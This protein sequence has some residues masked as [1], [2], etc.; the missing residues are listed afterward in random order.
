MRRR[1]FKLRAAICEL[2]SRELL[3]A[4]ATLSQPSR[5]SLFAL[6]EFSRSSVSALAARSALAQLS[7]LC[8]LS[9]AILKFSLMIIIAVNSELSIV[10]PQLSRCIYCVHFSG[11]HDWLQKHLKATLNISPHVPS[12]DH[13][14]YMDNPN[15]LYLSFGSNY[16]F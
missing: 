2:R 6:S 10:K 14:P 7:Q 11:I 1:A 8:Q 4:L 12:N 5:S 13:Y 9:L 16:Q 15:V 3:S